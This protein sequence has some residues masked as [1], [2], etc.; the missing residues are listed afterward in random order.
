MSIKLIINQTLHGYSNGH[1]L[2]ASSINLS[3]AS[4]RKMDILSDLSGPDIAEGFKYYFSGYF[5]ETERIIV[6]AKTWY[7]SEMSRPGCVWTHSLLFQED[8][9]DVLAQYTNDILSLFI[10]PNSSESIERYSSLLVVESP[11][12]KCKKMDEKKLQYLLWVML[13][14]KPANMIF[15]QDSEEYISELLFLWFACYTQLL[16]G[17]SFITGAMSIR[18][19]NEQ[20]V[21]L[22]FV[23]LELRNRVYHVG[24]DISV[25]KSIDEVQKFPPWVAFACD[26]VENNKWSLFVAFRA[27][28]GMAYSNF[29]YLT[30]FI[31]LYSV[32]C[33]KNNYINIYESLKLIDKLFSKEKMNIGNK[34]LQLYFAG[35]FT[36]W[37]EKVAYINIIIA[38][39]K[40]QWISINSNQLQ[41]LI[42]KGF[43]EDKY[44]S[45]KIVQYLCQIENIDIQER[46]LPIYAGLLNANTLEMFSCMD[47]S[48]CSV[49]VTLNPSLAECV[50]IWKQT[51]GYQK[52]I[53]D[54]LKICKNKDSLNLNV[55][56]TILDNSLYD[57]SLEVYSLLGDQSVKVFLEYLLQIRRLS[58]TDNQSMIAL[59]KEHSK[60][61][62]IMLEEQY[63]KLAVQQ[64]ET[65]LNIV[66]PYEDE[67]SSQTL[68]NLFNR[69]NVV[70]LDDKQKENISDFYLPIILRSNEYFPD[71]IVAFAVTNIHDRLAQ[72]MYPEIK[73]EKLQMLLPEI[74]WLNQWDKCKRLRKAIKK[75]GY[76]IKKIEQFNDD[77]L[78]IHLL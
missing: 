73:W 21:S 61:A 38:T 29:E 57:F 31:K 30:S 63:K 15:A 37:G 33:G 74:S 66:N 69:L 53:L 46:Y 3:D 27:L 8:D 77:E 58:C 2:L 50:A 56:Y 22:Q 19:D 52:G 62:T 68:F 75:K 16:Q 4:R 18:K 1:H 60:I 54:S 20:I 13:G 65:L 39:L 47:Y 11:I 14:H 32:F 5:L 34:L 6:L 26:I 51:K 71:N 48:I 35:S 43:L 45:K 28:F 24:S 44:G 25:M 55:A 40:F 78:D 76:K 41:L 64:I 72:L 23:P 17:Y 70:C 10:R 12:H 67:V 7:A 49:L 59:C 9:I 42:I 36:L